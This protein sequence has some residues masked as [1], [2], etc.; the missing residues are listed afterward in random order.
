MLATD[1]LPSEGGAR[2]AQP[3]LRGGGGMERE[4]LPGLP[5]GRDPRG[6]GEGQYVS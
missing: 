6:H 4:V 3:P 1:L 5:R 2:S